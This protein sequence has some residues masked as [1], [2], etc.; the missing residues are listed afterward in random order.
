MKEVKYI[1]ATITVR[2]E[3]NEKEAL[4]AY[5]KDNDLSISQVVRK[6]IKEFLMSNSK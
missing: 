1:L 6:A 3:E 2:L 4:A 5:A